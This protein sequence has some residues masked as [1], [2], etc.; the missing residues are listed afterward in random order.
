MVKSAADEESGRDV[1]ANE[2]VDLTVKRH[3]LEQA[4]NI[5]PPQ[6]YA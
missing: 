3:V 6:I 4:T 1:I 2:P 5:T